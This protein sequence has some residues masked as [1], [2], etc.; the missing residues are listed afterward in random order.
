MG[1]SF[2]SD[3][4]R[5]YSLVANSVF[6]W[7]SIFLFL[8]LWPPS[9]RCGSC[10]VDALGTT[11]LTPLPFNWFWFTLMV[12]VCCK[13][14]FLWWGVRSTVCVEQIFR[15]SSQHFWTSS[16]ILSLKML[17]IHSQILYFPDRFK[18]NIKN[19]KQT[20]NTFQTF[21][22]PYIHLLVVHTL[23]I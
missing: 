13:E 4:H 8:F 15:N 17:Q 3:I 21:P 23:T 7:L 12:F 10:D 18:K 2:A 19:K 16:V 1:Y 22:S 20:Q 6:L 9:L 5:R 14:K 11:G